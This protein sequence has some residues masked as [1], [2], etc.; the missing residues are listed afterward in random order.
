MKI[1][2]KTEFIPVLLVLLSLILGVYFYA[3]FPEKVAVHWNF[4]GQADNYAGRMQGA[5]AIPFMMTFMYG[6]FLLFPAVDPKRDRYKEFEKYFRIFRSVIIAVIFTV[7]IASGL[8]NMGY[9]VNIGPVVAGAI[10]LL[11]IVLGNFMGKIKNNWFMGI[12]TPWTLASENVWNKTHRLG[13]WLFIV[14]GLVIILAPY[15][16]YKLATILFIISIALMVLGTTVYSYCL[17]L[18]EQNGKKL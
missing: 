13:G 3:H 10:G 11:M 15:L 14:F 6:L 4:A 9:A 12:R 5:F 16:P 7:Y 18:K 1:S 8:S 2:I 17:Y